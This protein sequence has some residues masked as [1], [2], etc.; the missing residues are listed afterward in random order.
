MDQIDDPLDAAFSQN[1]EEPENVA[2]ELA[3]RVA[4]RLFLPLGVVNTLRE[5]F[6]QRNREKR[7][8]EVLSALKAELERL[9]D[10]S[11][12]HQDK[13]AA[14]EGR[15]TSSMYTEA[16]IVAAEEAVRAAS[17]AKLR[18]IASVLARG[19]D[20]E[21]E[22]SADEDD[23]ASFVR[24]I[25]QLSERDIRVLE[26]LHSVFADTMKMY[27]NL[28]N[29]DV[30]T[31]Q[32]AQL[33]NKAEESKIPRDDFYSYCKRLE[34]FGLAIEVPRNPNW[35]APG[36]YCFRPTRRGLKLLSLLGEDGGV[37]QTATAGGRNST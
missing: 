21:I 35:M 31:K 2:G 15:V 30:F 37:R 19:A 33:L 18:R 24:D 29:Q 8:W 13:I 10:K 9:S 1:R 16:I 17:D 20:P 6:S 7:V 34:G 3:I 12:N 11:K 32:A 25:G 27:S 28:H 5:H 14:L 26:V 23:L 4:G 36:D 22:I